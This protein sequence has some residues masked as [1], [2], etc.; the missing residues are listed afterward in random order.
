MLS[1]RF[2]TPL[3]LRV[4]RSP[5]LQAGVCAFFLLSLCSL[6]LT[7]FAWWLKILAVLLLGVVFRKQWRGRAELGGAAF[8]LTLRTN[9]MW[10]LEQGSEAI[11]LQ[12]HGQST[13]SGSLLLLCFSETQGR[14]RFDCVL[15]RAELSPLL[16]RR[17]RVYLRL[18]S[19]EALR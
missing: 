12:L 13:V 10:L 8:A 11:P 19:A 7:P 17:L 15:W 1:P 4:E 9:G 6:L 3:R 14:G 18:Y 5:R 16:W 2:A